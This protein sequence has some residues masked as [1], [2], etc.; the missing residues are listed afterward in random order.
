MRSLRL[1]EIVGIIGCGERI[2]FLCKGAFRNLVR[3][4]RLLHRISVLHLKEGILE[5]GA[6]NLLL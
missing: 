4:G 6:L 1:I 2:P 5:K 3:G